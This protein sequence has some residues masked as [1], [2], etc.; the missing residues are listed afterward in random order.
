MFVQPIQQSIKQSIKKLIRL[1]GFELQLT[2]ISKSTHQGRGV[3]FIHIAKCGGL[4][5][6]AALRQ[7]F[8]S[9]GQARINRS[10]AIAAT[11]VNFHQQQPSPENSARF[12]DSHAQTISTIM[13]YHLGLNWSYLSGHS[14]VSSAMLSQYQHT[15]DFVT[16]LR[17][18]ISRF[19]SHYIYTKLTNELPIMLPNKFNVDEVI[20]EAKQILDSRRGWHMANTS[21]M[22]LTGRYPIDIDDAIAMQDE[23]KLNLSKFAVVGFL[24][25]LEAFTAQIKQTTSKHIVIKHRNATNDFIEAYQVQVAQTLKAFFNEKASQEKIKQLCQSEIANYRQ[26]KLR[27][28]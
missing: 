22:C 28:G 8:A 27:Y 7:A 6:D 14:A 16:V 13:N 17:E 1:T 11:L 9:P 2:N 26:A 3:V 20:Q 10:A 25:N 18:P 21:T 23:V 12:G 19:I 4:S 5:I 24:D 15:Y